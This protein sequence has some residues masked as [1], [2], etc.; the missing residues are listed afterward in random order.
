VIKKISETPQKWRLMI[1]FRLIGCDQKSK[2]YYNTSKSVPWKD[3]LN[4][5]SYQLK[6]TD[7]YYWT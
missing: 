7:E 2:S 3:A 6:S 5:L 4:F 1:F